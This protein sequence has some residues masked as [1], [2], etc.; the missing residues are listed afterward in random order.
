MPAK[1][2]TICYVHNIAERLTQDFTVKEITGITRIKDDDPTK[3]VKNINGYLTL[4]FYVEE[5]LGNRKLTEFWVEARHDP[6]N[7]YYLA[8]KTNSINQNMRSTTAILM[9][10][11]G[12]NNNRSYHPSRG[13]TSRRRG[14]T[15]LAQMESTNTQ[16]LSA[17][18]EANPIPTNIN[19]IPN[20]EIS[21]ENDN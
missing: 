19:Q 3:T 15:T 6:N 2:N 8:N 7:R 11:Q 1:L 21:E 18:L 17:A 12:S 5:S 4:N 9:N 16:N 10:Q 14:R 20:N 13:A